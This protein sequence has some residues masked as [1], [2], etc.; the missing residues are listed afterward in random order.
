MYDKRKA[1]ATTLRTA[2]LATDLLLLLLSASAASAVT[3]TV[4]DNGR[5]VSG[6]SVVDMWD[7]T[8]L[9][10]AIVGILGHSV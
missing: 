7:C 4:D 1:K 10:Q 2:A 9:M 5:D 8:Y 3:I 6:D